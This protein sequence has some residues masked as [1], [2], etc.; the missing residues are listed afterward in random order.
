MLTEPNKA[1]Y[2]DS[3]HSLP[4]NFFPTTFNNI[5]NDE[6]PREFLKNT[7]SSLS[8]TPKILYTALLMQLSSTRILVADTGAAS[9]AYNTKG[10]QY[11]FNSWTVTS[12]ESAA[13]QWL[14]TYILTDWM[15]HVPS[16]WELIWSMAINHRYRQPSIGLLTSTPMHVQLSQRDSYISVI[17]PVLKL[18]GARLP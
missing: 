8:L 1:F 6:R 9:D 3:K 10:R 16:Q 14:L 2:H 5:N 18:R 7:M 15:H 12:S 13:T 4:M 11:D 17:I